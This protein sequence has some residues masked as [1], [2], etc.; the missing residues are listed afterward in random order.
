M[1]TALQS[2]ADEFVD[3]FRTSLTELGK[4]LKVDLMAAREY[5]SER[6][7]VLSLAVHEPGFREAVIASRDSVAL[8]LAGI[9]I[10]RADALDN[11][12]IGFAEGGLA[13]A[14][15]AVAALG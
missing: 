8:H 10:A 6:M 5:V 2:V 9:S 12:L 13:I 14:A 11:R 4:E 15:R 1:A 7:R 3:Q